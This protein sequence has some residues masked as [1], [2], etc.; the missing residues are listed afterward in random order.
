MKKRTFLKSSFAVIKV[1]ALP[2]I[3]ALDENPLLNPVHSHVEHLGEPPNV[4]PPL[5]P[6]SHEVRADVGNA[7]VPQEL[8]RRLYRDH[9][10][11]NATPRR[12]RNDGDPAVNAGLYQG[13]YRAEVV[14]G[15]AAAAGKHQ[16]G[17]THRVLQ[18]Q[19]LTQQGRL[20]RVRGAPRY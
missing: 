11:G 19:E 4:P 2:E 8:L 12:S 7:D 15:Y 16:S 9:R 5:L 6:R 10:R 3:L 13:L 18:L 17:V 1:A 20:G 14:H